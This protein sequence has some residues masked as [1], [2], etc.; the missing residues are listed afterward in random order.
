MNWTGR[1]TNR[2]TE[3]LSPRGYQSR[4]RSDH[5]NQLDRRARYRWE[6]YPMSARKDPKEDLLARDFDQLVGAGTM[7]A[8]RV[9]KVGADCGRSG[10]TFGASSA[11]ILRTSEKPP[12]LE[13]GLLVLQT[14]PKTNY[15]AMPPIAEVPRGVCLISQTLT[16]YREW[17][18]N[19]SARN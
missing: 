17:N 2:D 16:S 14:S 13:L 8:F 9:D 3:V 5:A 12:S 15:N 10:L 4:T 18:A 1:R 7:G 19:H 11:A 6:T